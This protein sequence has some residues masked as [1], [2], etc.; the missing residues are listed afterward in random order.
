MSLLASEAVPGVAL[1]FM[2]EDH[3]EATALINRVYE[4][5]LAV[6]YGDEESAAIT[7]ALRLLYQHDKE[8]FARE[9]AQMQQYDFPPYHC[10]KGEHDRV[11]AEL[12]EVLAAWESNQDTDQLEQYMTAVM[13]PW[14]LNHINTM[15]T[16]TAMYISSRQ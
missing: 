13:L 2:N 16:V 9:E 5:I 1:D 15:D 10:H 7:D 4:L 8:H 12:Q 6:R 11:L 3:Q 14:F